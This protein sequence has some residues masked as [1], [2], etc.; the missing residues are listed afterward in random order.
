MSK[1]KPA[2]RTLALY[3]GR[4]R[5]GAI[6]ETADECRAIGPTGKQLGTFK[7]RALALAAIDAVAARACRRGAP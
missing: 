1:H 5:L 4:E 2:P 7:T 3:A 6:V